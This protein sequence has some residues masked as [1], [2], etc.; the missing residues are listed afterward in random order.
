VFKVSGN[1]GH[2]IKGQSSQQNVNIFLVKRIVKV[3]CICVNFK[4]ETQYSVQV[5]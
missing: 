3:V 1:W 4:C 5:S 2:L